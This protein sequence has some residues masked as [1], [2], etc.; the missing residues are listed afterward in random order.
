MSN[1]VT[2]RLA[3]NNERGLITDFLDTHWGS[4]HPLIHCTIFSSIIICPAGSFNLR[5]PFPKTNCAP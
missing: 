4:R 5:L 1:P 2:C 3:Q